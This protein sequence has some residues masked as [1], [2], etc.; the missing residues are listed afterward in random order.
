MKWVKIKSWHIVVDDLLDAY[1][2]RCGRR[3]MD[4]YTVADLP[5]GEKSCESCLR[6]VGVRG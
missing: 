5:M 3:A 6:L 4:T 2:T 1:L